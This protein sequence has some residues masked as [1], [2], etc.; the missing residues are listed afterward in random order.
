M[1]VALPVMD[2]RGACEARRFCQMLPR[3]TI[4]SDFLD[5]APAFC[6]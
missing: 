3:L 4:V 5:P 6:V 1:V 2:W